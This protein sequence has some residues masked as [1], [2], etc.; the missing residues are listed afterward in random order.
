MNHYRTA[1]KTIIYSKKE[2]DQNS[3]AKK[4]QKNRSYVKSRNINLCVLAFFSWKTLRSSKILESGK[5]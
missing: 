1:I 4:R 5:K 2:N 3:I